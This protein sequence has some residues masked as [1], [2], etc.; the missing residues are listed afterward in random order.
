MKKVTTLIAA[1]Y[2]KTICRDVGFDILFAKL[3]FIAS[4][5][6]VRVYS[7]ANVYLFLLADVG[8]GLGIADGEDIGQFIVNIQ[9]VRG[10]P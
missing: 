7:V 1:R 9:Y 3:E 10:L 8:F 5:P 6:F 2:I 4:L